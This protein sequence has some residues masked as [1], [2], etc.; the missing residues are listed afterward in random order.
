MTVLR[1]FSG[2]HWFTDIL[3]GVLLGSA[4]PV[5]YALAVSLFGAAKEAREV[6]PG[7]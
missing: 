5:L 2:V 3:G 4:L 6:P 7:T 1:L